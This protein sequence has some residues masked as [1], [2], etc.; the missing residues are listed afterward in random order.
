MPIKYN[1]MSCFHYNDRCT[2]IH[3]LPLR[4]NVFIFYFFF[5]NIRTESRLK[6]MSI[7]FNCH[8][9]HKSAVKV[10]STEFRLISFKRNLR[11]FKFSKQI[12]TTTRFDSA[13]VSFFVHHSNLLLTKAV[14]E[15]MIF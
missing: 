7:Q 10:L 14:S 15:E 12:F 9:Y 3:E 5:N 4:S 8:W 1:V 11:I 6:K 13:V 2:R